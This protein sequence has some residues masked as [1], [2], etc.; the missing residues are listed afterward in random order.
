[1]ELYGYSDK[2]KD[3]TTSKL[4]QFSNKLSEK[5]NLLIKLCLIGIP[6]LLLFVIQFFVSSRTILIIIG[7]FIFSIISLI[8]SIFILIEILNK[9]TGKLFD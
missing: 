9:D 4:L 8:Y 1:M 6:I 7:V 5:D 2:S 3:Y